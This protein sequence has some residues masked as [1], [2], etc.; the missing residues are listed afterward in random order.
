MNLRDGS[1]LARDHTVVSSRGRAFA[2]N[3]GALSVSPRALSECRLQCD[4]EK[5]PN[6]LSWTSQGDDRGQLKADGNHQRQQGPPQ[7]HHTRAVG[8]S[9]FYQCEARIARRLHCVEAS[10]A[11]TATDKPGS[12]WRGRQTTLNTRYGSRRLMTVAL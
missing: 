11:V 3:Q 6:M 1:G 7:Q 12:R 4:G 10:S 9:A 5:R 8:R 2:G